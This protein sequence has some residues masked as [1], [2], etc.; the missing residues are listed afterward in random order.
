MRESPDTR[1]VP[2]GSQ[3][4][5]F[6]LSSGFHNVLQGTNSQPRNRAQRGGE[7]RPRPPLDGG[8]RGSCHGVRCYAGLFRGLA[9]YSACKHFSPLSQVT[10]TSRKGQN[11]TTL[12]PLGPALLLF[13]ILPPA[14]LLIVYPGDAAGHRL[15]LPTPSTLLEPLSCPQPLIIMRPRSSVTV[16]RKGADSDLNW[17]IRISLPGI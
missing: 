16:F 13:I 2:V 11:D 7:T 10:V 17:P 6:S 5:S 14:R 1:P 15:S 9:A 4:F 3:S 8:D 12:I